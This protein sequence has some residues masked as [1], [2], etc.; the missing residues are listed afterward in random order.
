MITFADGSLN[1][2]QSGNFPPALESQAITFVHL[3]SAM[4]LDQVACSSNSEAA[5]FRVCSRYESS[6]SLTHAK[7]YLGVGLE[8]LYDLQGEA[9]GRGRCREL[10]LRSEGGMVL[11]GADPGS[12]CRARFLI[13]I[14]QLY[15][16]YIDQKDNLRYL[17]HQGRENP[18]NQ[19]IAAGAGKISFSQLHSQVG[20]FSLQAVLELNSGKQLSF[21]SFS[22]IARRPVI[23]LILNL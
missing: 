3:D 4:L 19:P 1:P 17:G 2:I 5:L 12:L 13:P 23:N 9:R 22:H 21:W 8:R 20:V 7:G 14:M 10:V 11:P 18:E 16:L 6:L 15:T